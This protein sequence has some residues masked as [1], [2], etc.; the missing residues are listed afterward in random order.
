[1]YEHIYM[2]IYI[3]IFPGRSSLRVDDKM[4]EGTYIRCMYDTCMFICICIYIYIYIY[5]HTSVYV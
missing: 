3:Y 5:I 2:Y 1:M 4:C